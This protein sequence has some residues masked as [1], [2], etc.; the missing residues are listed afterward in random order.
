MGSHFSRTVRSA[1]YVL[2]Y[3]VLLEGG[4][5]STRERLELFAFKLVAD[6]DLDLRKTIENIK[7]GQVEGGIVVYGSGVLD[8]HKIKPSATALTAC[9]DTNFLSDIL[10]VLANLLCEC[11]E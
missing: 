9:S 2:G 5:K 4:D 6:G 11:R 1:V 8:D 3:H 10:E 7:F